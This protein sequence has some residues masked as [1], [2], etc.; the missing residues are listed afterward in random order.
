MD[1]N[2]VPEWFKEYFIILYIFQG[3]KDVISHL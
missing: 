1:Q 2:L 3:Q